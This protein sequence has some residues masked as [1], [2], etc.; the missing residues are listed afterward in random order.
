MANLTNTYSRV[1]HAA[2]LAT[3][4]FFS[5][6]AASTQYGAVKITTSPAGAEVINLKDDS[7]LGTTPVE[8]SFSGSS[9]TAEFIT[10]QLRKKG[11]ADRIT[12]FWINRRHESASLAKDNAIDLHVDLDKE[13]SD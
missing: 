7:S 5:G 3:I 2:L 6:C 4:L 12:S 13:A 8:V 11:H 10:I 1:F 9:G